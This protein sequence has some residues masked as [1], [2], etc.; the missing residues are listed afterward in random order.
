MLQTE[1]S[2]KPTY[3]NNASKEIGEVKG[4]I[5][6]TIKT[7]WNS[8]NQIIVNQNISPEQKN[9][10]LQKEN[11]NLINSLNEIKERIIEL[12]NNISFSTF[13]LVYPNLN[14][15]KD[16]AEN[17]IFFQVRNHT[18]EELS[19]WGNWKIA[20]WYQVSKVYKI[21]TKDIKIFLE[22]M[23]KYRIKDISDNGIWRVTQ[24]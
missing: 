10:F 23:E 8:T 16:L 1:F 5:I 2:F 17:N 9:I 7:G 21:N 20:Y 12:E 15:E 22:L 24:R 14:F 4:I 6:E 3:E 13:T 11:I 18:L 19:K